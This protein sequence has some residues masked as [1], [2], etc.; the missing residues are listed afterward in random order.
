VFY[1]LAVAAL[2]GLA[3][4]L[5]SRKD[6]T[7]APAPTAGPN[8]GETN[9]A[10]VRAIGEGG[11][12]VVYEA[13]DR[14]LDRRVAIK[15]LR[16]DTGSLPD[17]EQLLKEAKTVAALHHPNIVS[18][19]SI[20]SQ[21]GDDYIVFEF[22]EGRTVEDILQERK[23]L[24]LVETRSILDPVCQALEFAHERGIIHRDLKPANVMLT[25]HGHV[26]VMDFGIAR[27]MHSSDKPEVPALAP[28][29]NFQLTHNIIGTPPYLAPEAESGIIRPEGDVFAL[30]VMLYRML[31]G[32]YPFPP[33]A[34]VEQK[35]AGRYTPLSLILRPLPAGVDALV[36]DSLQPNADQRLRT[37]KDFRDRLAALA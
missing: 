10:I 2:L 22:V 15:R 25:T 16:N 3:V 11:M 29:Q 30:G 24:N 35:M 21:G 14:T 4:F 1:V 28:V 37:P 7:A 13:L 26:K 23:R 34:T 17:R 27:R 9:F 32:L 33:P 31:S 20:V 36:S 12:G 19:H 18:I 5:R 6:A 8:L